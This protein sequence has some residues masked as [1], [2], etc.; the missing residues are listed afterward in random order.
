MKFSRV[1]RGKKNSSEVNA[2]DDR[3]RLIRFYSND[4]F[5]IS[6]RRNERRIEKIEK[7]I[8]TD[9]NNDRRVESSKEEH[10]LSVKIVGLCVSLD[11]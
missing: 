10:S 3:S 5:L 8:R 6:R 2:K 7:I 1:C 9:G 11:Y 4:R